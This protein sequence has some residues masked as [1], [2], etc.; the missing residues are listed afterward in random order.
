MNVILRKAEPRDSAELLRLLKYIAGLHRKGRPDIFRPAGSKYDEAALAGI[1]RD[2]RKPIFVAAD[3]AQH[4]LGYAFCIIR[5]TSGDVML[6]DRKTLYLDDLCVDERFRGQGIGKAL[7]EAVQKYGAE[8]GAVSVELNVWDF[9]RSAA[10]FYKH[11]GFSV[12]KSI[13]EL[14]IR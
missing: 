6:Q 1:L 11:F 13:L 9:N 12:Q 3:D 5:E 4:I 7:L 8:I 2:E 10:A 14:P